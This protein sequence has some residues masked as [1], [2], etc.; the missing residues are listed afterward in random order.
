MGYFEYKKDPCPCLSNF[1]TCKILSTSYHQV[2]TLSGQT[3]RKCG[4]TLAFKKDKRAYE[5]ECKNV[6][7]DQIRIELQDENVLTLC[8]VE[9][10]GDYKVPTCKH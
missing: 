4:E 8:E 3:R 9:V 1:C 5:F 10:Y 6:I 7:A 2:F